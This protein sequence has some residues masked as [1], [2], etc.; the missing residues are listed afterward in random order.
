MNVRTKYGAS[1]FITFINDYSRFGH[2]YLISHKPEALDCFK[3][4]LNIVENQLDSNVK[5]LRTDR[6][7]EYLSE[8]FKELCNE[9]KKIDNWLFLK[10]RN[11]MKEY[12]F[13]GNDKV[14]DDV[15]KSFNI[16]L[17]RCFVNCYLYTYPSSFKIS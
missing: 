12:N 14:N 13:F 2:V 8:Q 11:K 4:Y 1:Y 9:K 3:L 5:V 17:K 10:L 15:I 6:R 7:R 16:L